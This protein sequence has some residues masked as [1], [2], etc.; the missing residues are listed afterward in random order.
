MWFPPLLV[1]L[2]DFPLFLHTILIVNSRQK[3][4]FYV[5][6]RYKFVY[7]TDNN[8]IYF[9]LK[10][11]YRMCLV[12][13]RLKQSLVCSVININKQHFYVQ[14]CM[15]C[16]VIFA[17]NVYS[18]ILFLHSYIH[19]VHTETNAWVVLSCLHF[20]SLWDFNAKTTTGCP[21]IF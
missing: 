9:W 12:S 8:N 2:I 16:S 14:E 7:F 15:L 10:H 17:C 18:Y 4:T 21:L 5:H 3:W 13:K 19:Y 6:Y 20:G 11:I 1:S